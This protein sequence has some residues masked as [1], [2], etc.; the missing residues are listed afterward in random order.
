M[1]QVELYVVGIIKTYSMSR[2]FDFIVIRWTL[3]LLH[4]GKYAR[5][6]LIKA[7]EVF[8]TRRAVPHQSQ[9]GQVQFFV[10]ASR[11]PVNRS[12]NYDYWTFSTKS[13]LYY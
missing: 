11:R 13:Q 10:R 8:S 2:T 6:S 1:L 9:V 4:M 12:I 7:Y 5:A 3:F